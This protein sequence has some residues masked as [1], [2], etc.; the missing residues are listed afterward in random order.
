MSSSNGN[1][2]NPTTVYVFQ[3]VLFHCDI[4]YQ[5]LKDQIKIFEQEFKIY[6][7]DKTEISHCKDK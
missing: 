3:S 1:S 4:E 7:R 2:G 5:I 6:G